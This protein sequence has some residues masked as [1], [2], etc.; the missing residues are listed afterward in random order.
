[1]SN[2]I[3]Y[4]RN[5]FW[6]IFKILPSWRYVVQCS[7]SKKLSILRCHEIFIKDCSCVGPCN[8]RNIE[9][10]KIVDFSHVFSAP[11]IWTDIKGTKR[12]SIRPIRLSKKE[13]K[14]MQNSYPSKFKGCFCEYDSYKVLHVCIVFYVLEIIFMFSIW[15]I[16]L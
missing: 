2:W 5:I 16:Q 13:K 14:E 10:M 7:K 9:Q 12:H 8:S 3:N 11:F 4:R 1:M 15:K 6:N